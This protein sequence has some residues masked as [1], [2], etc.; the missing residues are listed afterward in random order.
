ML[1]KAA[2]QANRSALSPPVLP[3]SVDAEDELEEGEI[4]EPSSS[5]AG[6]AS[7]PAGE[8]Q[9]SVV[10][11]RPVDMGEDSDDE[12]AFVYTGASSAAHV[13]ASQA[14]EDRVE[15]PEVTDGLAALSIAAPSDE[16]ASAQPTLQI[17]KSPSIPVDHAQLASLATTGPLASLKTFFQHASSEEGGDHSAFAL[18][19]EPSPASGLVPLH[20]AAKEGRSDIV[21]WLVE[22]AGALAE[23]EDREGEVRSD[24][25]VEG[26]VQF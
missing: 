24:P 6:T 9:A 1:L 2:S 15:E 21:K 7:I 23:L 25:H 10:L 19:N 20:Y 16:L 14:A 22:E 18:A 17:P 12:E 8:A 11:E 26:Y 4:R 5:A 13:A 3:L